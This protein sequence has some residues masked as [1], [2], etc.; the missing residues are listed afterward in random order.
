MALELFRADFCETV[1]QWS[2]FDEY[3]R[4]EKLKELEDA[5]PVKVDLERFFHIKSMFIAHWRLS[6]IGF[7]QPLCIILG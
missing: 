6:D 5:E 4:S 1:T 7:I 3:E 2:I